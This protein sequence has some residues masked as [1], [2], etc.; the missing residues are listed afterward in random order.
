MPSSAPEGWREL[1]DERAIGALERAAR[2]G[3][4]SLGVDAL[5][6]VR[7]IGGDEAARVLAGFAEHPDM[8]MRLVA[9]GR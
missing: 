2:G 5:L 6:A 1:G 3:D 9:R 4:V 7:Q 8:R